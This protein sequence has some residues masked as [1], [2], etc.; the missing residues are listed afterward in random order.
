MRKIAAFVLLVLFC[1]TLFPGRI[2]SAENGTELSLTEAA[3]AP[4]D[5]VTVEVKISRRY[6]DR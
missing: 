1:V 2:L 4:G 3:A 5:T 6:R